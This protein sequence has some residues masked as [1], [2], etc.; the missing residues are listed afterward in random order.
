MCEYQILVAAGCC[1]EW[2]HLVS[3]VNRDVLFATARP[4]NLRQLE[5][6]AE[7]RPGLLGRLE[8]PGGEV[9]ENKCRSLCALHSL[10]S[11]CFRIVC[12]YLTLAVIIICRSV[13]YIYVNI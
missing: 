4:R 5:Y 13:L 6:T 11:S 2:K 7:R 3:T 8:A 12:V 1:A 9:E 10:L